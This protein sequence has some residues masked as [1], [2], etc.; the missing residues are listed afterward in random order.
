M[1]ELTTEIASM[2]KE[3]EEM[4]LE[5]N[6]MGLL[7]K[8]AE[9]LAKEL[10]A[11]NLQLAIH[12]EFLDRQRIG[13]TVDDVRED[14]EATKSE[15]EELAA[16]LESGYEEQKKLEA[17][18]GQHEKR[19]EESQSAW[20]HVLTR[21]SYQENSEL[22]GIEQEAAAL[23]RSIQSLESE[24]AKLGVKRQHL[25]ASLSSG[26]DSFLKKEIV[27]SVMRL[28]SLE[29]QRDELSDSSCSSDEKGRLL[30]QIKR[31][32]KEVAAM[33]T[34]VSEVSAEID[35][36]K[37]EL[38]AYEDTDAMEK[39]RELKRKE[40]E[41]DSFLSEFDQTKRDEVIRIREMGADVNGLLEKIT[42]M[43]A[44]IDGLKQSAPTSSGKGSSS[45]GLERLMD[46]KRRLELDL[47]KIGQLEVKIQDEIM[48][49]GNKIKRLE[50]EIDK[51]SDMDGLQKEMEGKSASLTSER[52]Q[53]K[54]RTKEL[55][56]TVADLEES[57]SVLRKD[58]EQNGLF[59][60][61][62]QLESRLT[63]VLSTNER[64][65]TAISEIDYSFMRERVLDQAL[66]YNQK[67]Q[68]F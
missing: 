15:N 50:A 30:A 5:E 66:R 24:I 20:Q 27:Q 22:A 28:R 34:R 35:E 16:S 48:N 38:E 45:N 61:T 10:A 47:R 65:A 17:V 6:R 31:D 55:R 53:L 57:L 33:E 3:N 1:N 41:M 40:Q 21:F 58:L 4:A 9:S 37:A 46:D 11:G 51:Y 49:L 56:G 14:L 52:D 67:L 23:S 18:I 13:D 39:Y 68:G 19:K 2:T 43:V 54:D 64:L 59:V 29:K 44:H 60:K 36:M 12:N 26:P 42:R 25:E 32:N 63:S 8:K 7:K 62:K